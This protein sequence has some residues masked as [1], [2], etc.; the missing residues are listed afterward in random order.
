[1]MGS[2]DSDN[3]EV[4]AQYNWVIKT[5]CTEFFHLLQRGEY[6]LYLV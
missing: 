6:L 1:M 4:Q 5:N 3:I 2:L